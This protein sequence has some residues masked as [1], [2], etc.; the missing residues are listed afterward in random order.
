MLQTYF[1]TAGTTMGF[2][3]S[4]YRMEYSFKQD[5]F[6][7]SPAGKLGVLS[8]YMP[9]PWTGVGEDGRFN[10][11][12]PGSSISELMRRN[13]Y[14][15]KLIPLA[16]PRG[17]PGLTESTNLVIYSEGNLVKQQSPDTAQTSFKN[18]LNDPSEVDGI[19]Y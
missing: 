12:F 6:T 11:P 16:A 19:K 14:S 15:T 8:A 10:S 13:F 5:N 9:G 4:H 18:I 7:K 2:S 17:G 1:S 3:A